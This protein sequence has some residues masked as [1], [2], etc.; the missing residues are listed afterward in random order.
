MD[1]GKGRIRRALFFD[2]DGTLL[3]EQDRRIPDSAVRALRAARRRGC[4][5]FV[6]TGRTYCN[7]NRELE[8][9]ETDGVVCGCGTH[10]VAEGRELYHYSLPHAQGVRLK[11][12][13]EACGLDGILEGA[14][15]C[16]GRGDS[17]MPEIL[18]LK[19][20][21]RAAGCLSEKD[22]GR[23]D[24]EFDKCYLKAGAESRPEELFGRMDFMDVIDRGE[25]YFECVPQGHTKATGIKR[26]LKEYG[27]P[28]ESAYVFGDSSNDLSMFQYA[29][30]CILMGKHSPVLEPYATFLTKEVEADGIA[31]ALLRLGLIERGDMEP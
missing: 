21:L 14:A 13:I 2:V 7:L 30:N 15:G 27:L 12:D 20:K 28:R 10:I 18:W 4:L 5:V 16:Y 31:Y 24:Y 25:G 19:E 29:P 6:N 26:V 8:V 3:S 11:R 23:E 17:W 9:L 1:T 22:W